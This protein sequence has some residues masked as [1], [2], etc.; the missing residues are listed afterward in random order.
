GEPPPETRSAPFSIDDGDALSEF[1]HD[2]STIRLVLIDNADLLFSSHNNP[3]RAQV[4]RQLDALAAVAQEREVAIVLLA[5]V[6]QLQRNPFASRL[7]SAMRDACRL[8]YFLAPDLEDPEQRLLF[9]LK[10]TLSRTT[11][12]RRLSPLCGASQGTFRT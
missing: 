10:N 4:Q 2:H 12:T 9:C 6:P 8:V 11:A 7:F 3:A 5:G 1:L